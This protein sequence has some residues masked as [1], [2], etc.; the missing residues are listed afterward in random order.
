MN[1]TNHLRIAVIAVAA[2]AVLGLLG[3]PVGAY[4]PLAILVVCPLMMYFMMRGMNHGGTADHS[5]HQGHS[6]DRGR[7]DEPADR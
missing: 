1:H 2:V 7:A 4:A 5:A 3:V 6:G